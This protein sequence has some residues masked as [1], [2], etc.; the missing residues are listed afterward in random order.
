MEVL[1]DVANRVGLAA[2]EARRV[3]VERRFEQAID[4][5]WTNSRRSGVT[6]V[7]T[8]AAGGYGVVGAQPYEVLEQLM[9]AAGAKRRAA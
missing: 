3:L 8:F 2:D 9:E 1:V 6:G 5:D 4:A 7:P